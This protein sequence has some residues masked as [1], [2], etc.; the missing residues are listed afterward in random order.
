[1]TFF[2]GQEQPYS[3]TVAGIVLDQDH[4]KHMG[5][6]NGRPFPALNCPHPP[7]TAASQP[8]PRTKT[9]SLAY[10]GQKLQELLNSRQ[11][12]GSPDP[13]IRLELNSA[14]IFGGQI[15][16]SFMDLQFIANNPPAP[17]GQPLSPTY[18]MGTKYSHGISELGQFTT[19]FGVGVHLN[20]INSRS[21]LLNVN[22]GDSQTP[23]TLDLQ[24]ETGGPTEITGS[25]SMDVIKFEVSIRFTLRY[26]QPTGAVDLTGWV[27]DIN[28]VTYTPRLGARFTR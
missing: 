28:A 26:H 22:Q 17:D 27:D 5:V 8:L 3:W 25:I 2:F 12:A 21:L 20:E 14:R 10:V 11:A 13:L 4:H 18:Q 6:Y 1:M 24:F 9:I 15:P 19:W 16:P 7:L 23:L